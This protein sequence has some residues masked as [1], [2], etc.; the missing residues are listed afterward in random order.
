[1]KTKTLADL[2]KRQDNLE[3]RLG[4]TPTQRRATLARLRRRQELLETEHGLSTHVTVRTRSGKEVRI[5]RPGPGRS[6]PAADVRRIL[7]ICEMLEQRG[8]ECAALGAYCAG[9]R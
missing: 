4:L 8:S 7:N 3:N 5:A 9:G 2:R 1:M 6:V